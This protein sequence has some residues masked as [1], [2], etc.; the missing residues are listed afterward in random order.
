MRDL[1]T[2]LANAGI[3]MTGITLFNANAVSGNGQFIVGGGTFSGATRAYIVRYFDQ[4][5]ATPTPVIAGLTTVASVQSSINDLGDA[6]LGLMAQ[7]HGLA[8]P[9]LGGDKPMGL[10]NEAGVFASGGSAA[11]GG[12]L[13]YSWGS[14]FSLLGGLSYAQEDYP[15]AELKHAG[16]GAL[17]LQYVHGGWGWWHPFFEAGGWLAPNAALSFSR[18]YMNGAGTAT[19]TGQ[20]HGDLSY[21]YARAG[22]LVARSR[23]DQVL[24]A[25]EYGRERMAIDAYT[26]PISAQNPFEAHVAAGTDSID[27]AKLRLQWS[28]RFTSQLD[29]TLWVAG[30]RGFNRSSE[31]SAVVP[32]I[33]SLMPTDLGT[34]TW[35]E[36]GARI[37]YK[38]TDTVTLDGF[39]NGVAGGAGIDSRIHAGAGLRFHF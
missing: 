4:E 18:T 21:L 30:V 6:R 22:L 14:G 35:A 27:L 24:V 28:H 39:V 23:W 2:L 19:G 15:N 36:Y 17:A 31:L 37:G 25:A 20:T 7:Q 38:L 5:T 13:R 33:G 32:G 12:F 3:N 29:T 10:S 1:N 26:E 34:L 11:G 9:L 16:M 8:A